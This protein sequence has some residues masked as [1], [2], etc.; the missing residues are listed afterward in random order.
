[1]N[2]RVYFAALALVSAVLFLTNLGGIDLWPPDEPRYAQVAREMTETGDYLVPRINGEPYTEKPPLLFWIQALF[3]KPF[4]DV[5]EFP[6]RLPSALAGIVTVLATFAFVRRLY[7]DRIAFWAGFIL[8]TT[9]RFWWQG[10]FAQIDMLLTACMTVA[11]LC[12]W[13]WHTER[14]TGFLIGFYLA[15]AAGVYAKGPPAAIFPLLLAWT[16][17][18]KRKEE[19]K[20]L[21][22]ALGY[23]FVAIA[24][25][26]WLIPARM[27]ISVETAAGSDFSMGSNLFRQTIGRFVLG[28]SHANPPWYY[29]ANLPVDLFPWTIFLPWSVVWI[30]RRRREGEPM[31]FLLSWIVPAFVFFSISIGK[32]AIYLLPLYPAIAALLSA[33]IVDLMDGERVQWRRGTAAVWAAILILAA[34]APLV[35]PFTEYGDAWRPSLGLWTVGGLALAGHTVY[36]AIKTE[37]RQHLTHVAAHFTVLAVAAAL[38]VFPVVNPYKSARAYCTPLRALAE[39]NVDYDLYSLAFSRE[40]YIYYSKHAH[41]VTPRGLLHVEE[42]DDLELQEAA[43][44][45]RKLLRSIQKSAES[46]PVENIEC[47]TDDEVRLLNAA[48]RENLDLSPEAKP[49]VNAYEDKMAEVLA[50]LFGAMSAPNPAFIIVQE[51]DWHW[52]VAL[53]PDARRFPIVRHE[54]VGSRE[55]LLV[56]NRPAARL[57][58]EI[59]QSG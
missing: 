35:L 16:F 27:A 33:S 7:D 57:V 5:S 15:I 3:S 54:N 55:V 36:T 46:I 25:A 32:R 9:Q 31:R 45:Q 58:Q 17:Y 44:L 14:R 21:R 12:F 1:M 48:I 39:S 38:I 50:D 34:V 43:S 52:V 23:G 37:E 56:A 8:A 4:G 30:W 22:L 24:I 47:I 20:R 29:L 19:R 13:R 40:E 28:V 18:W 10:R 51:E 6:A 41:Y 11:L 42:L 2:A 53:N 59:G 49:Y 26:A